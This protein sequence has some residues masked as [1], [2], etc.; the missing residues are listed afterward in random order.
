MLSAAAGGPGKGRKLCRGTWLG[1]GV[2]GSQS[3][4]WPCSPG[5]RKLLREY[6]CPVLQRTT[7]GNLSGP[8]AAC[9]SV[10]EGLKAGGSAWWGGAPALAA[11]PPCVPISLIYLI[12][13]SHIPGASEAL[14]FLCTICKTGKNM[15]SSHE[16]QGLRAQYSP[17]LPNLQPTLFWDRGDRPHITH[18][19]H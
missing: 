2:Q 10:G 13:N 4:L 9:R 12:S 11:L 6:L 15:Q 16:R 7:A 18:H 14:F 3:H 19:L 1:T 5:R 8:E 17:M